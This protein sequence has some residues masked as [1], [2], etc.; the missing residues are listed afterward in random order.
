[1]SCSSAVACITPPAVINN[2]ALNPEWLAKWNKVELVCPR[3]IE[4]VRYPNW[5][6]VE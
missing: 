4:A 2:K 6:Q 3:P 5:L 1:M